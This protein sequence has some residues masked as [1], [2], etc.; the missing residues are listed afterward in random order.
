MCPAS[1]C[2]KEGGQCTERPF[3]ENCAIWPYGAPKSQGCKNLI[4]ALYRKTVRKSDYVSTAD[5]TSQVKTLENMLECEKTSDTI[6]GVPYDVFTQSKPQKFDLEAIPE[7]FRGAFSEKSKQTLNAIT[8]FKKTAHFIV[9]LSATGKS[10]ISQTIVNMIRQYDAKTPILTMDGDNLREGHPL[11]QKY[12]EFSRGYQCDEQNPG[13]RCAY[14]FWSLSKF[15]K[16]VKKEYMKQLEDLALTEGAESHLIIPETPGIP[17]KILKTLSDRDDYQILVYN[18]DIGLFK[19]SDYQKIQEAG[20]TRGKISGKFYDKKGQYKFNFNTFGSKC[21]KSKIKYKNRPKQDLLQ[22]CAMIPIA[23]F[24]ASKAP[25]SKDCYCGFNTC[26][27][28][29]FCVV[30]SQDERICT[31][32]DTDIPIHHQ[33]EYIEIEKPIQRSN[34]MGHYRPTPGKA[35]IFEEEP[36]EDGDADDDDDSSIYREDTIYYDTLHRENAGELSDSKFRFNRE[37]AINHFNKTPIGRLPTLYFDAQ[38]VEEPIKRSN[39]IDMN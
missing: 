18:I 14:P 23:A 1:R 11:Y 28:G 24:A 32:N 13:K 21:Q 31:K 10:T 26:G 34:A 9:G 22:N 15:N 30:T 7:N 17:S 29:Q 20:K 37:A 3:T 8:S 2:H 27:V 33:D 6:C 38:E 25:L 36:F 35:S 5:P 19:W 4:D 39:A 16:E 12:V